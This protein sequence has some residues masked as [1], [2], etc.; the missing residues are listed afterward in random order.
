MK[1]LVLFLQLCIFTM[2]A[3]AQPGQLS[4][5]RIDHM[6]DLPVSLQIR[7]WDAVAR[8]YDSFV[9]DLDKTGTYL[10]LSRLGIQ[11][12]FNYA[13]NT[14]LFMDSYVGS[15]DHLNLAEAIN[16]LP[17]I[18]GASLVGIDKSNQQGMNWVAMAKDFYNLENGQNV[19]LNGYSTQSGNDWWYDLMPNVYFYQLNSLYPEGTPEF[20]TQF[21]AVA[22]QWLYCVRQLG[23][24]TSPWTIPNMNYRA[25]DL[26]TGQPLSEGVPEPESAG[27]IA[28]L[29]YNAY[30]ETGNREYM[31]GARQ[32]MD[33]LSGFT[34]N[35]SYELQLPYGT[36]A[37]ARMNAVE[38]DN[39][40]VQQLLDWCFERGPLRGWGAI[41]GNWNGQE[42]S[43]LIGEANDNGNDYAFVMNGFQQAAALAPLPKY[44]KRYARAL[45]KWLLN[46][47]HA[48]RLFYHNALPEGNQDSYAWAAA[49]DPSA[50]I[51]Y[52]AMKEVWQGVGPFA[53][54]DAIRGGW[55]STNLSLY[56]GSSVGYLAAVSQTTNVPGILQIDLNSTDFYGDNDLTSWMYFNPTTGSQ[57]VDVNLPL[58]DYGIYEAITETD[59]MASAS[60]T[61][62]L[63]IPSGEV[64]LIR[65]YSPGEAPESREGK[66][67][68]GD[69]VLDYHYQY[70]YESSL[71]VKALS[72]P[73]PVVAGAS[74]TAWAE[75]GNVSPQDIVQY[76]WYLNDVLVQGQ[77]T[78]QGSLTASETPSEI[79]LRSRI[80]FNDQ[81]A[82]DTLHLKVV[83]QILAP[84]MVTGIGS[85]ADYTATGGSNTFT[86]QVTPVAG[87][88]YTYQWSVT[89][90]TLGQPTG[91]SISWQAPA[92]PSVDTVRV[93]VTNQE[94]L[95]TTV[96][97]TIVVK[98]VTLAE[99]EPLIWYPFDND[100]QNAAADRFH[101]T[102]TGAEK[103]SDARGNAEGAY[104]FTS[105]ENIIS[106]PND[107]ELNFT[108]AV[109]LSC[110]VKAE[111]LG[112]ERYVISHGSW[113]QRYKLSIIPEGKFR[114]TVRTDAG[115]VDLDSETIL[116][117]DRYYH[118]TALFTG[119]SLELYIDGV[120]DAATGF[121]G[122]LLSSTHPLTLGR[123]DEVEINYA[124]LG[125]IDEVKV[126]DREIPVSQIEKLKD[127]WW[128]P[129]GIDP[130]SSVEAA[131]RIYPNPSEGM[132]T[133]EFSGT[134]HPEQLSLFAA[135]G[136]KVVEYQVKADESSIQLELPQ[137]SEGIYL[138][139][140]RMKDGKVFTRKVVG[141]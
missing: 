118:V 111:E 128:F 26:S 34:S 131:V 12:Q 35:P 2:L 112:M 33:F 138:L 104:R 65:L 27:S 19:Y 16:I 41:V 74:F 79:I 121:S 3:L 61:Y 8:D 22:D 123:Q 20:D 102:V 48:S 24:S 106:T 54:G 66:L 77:T 99:Q 21:T 84:P 43:G 91:A 140:I 62:Q 63:T 88:T 32:A 85:A 1:R 116:E 124:L 67:Y 82:E 132:V 122:S 93:T 83:S 13:D 135:D 129:V 68:S 107:P 64:R 72:A 139:R 130:G 96:S 57:Q 46:L 44:D 4:I 58:G 100:D 37:A 136:R 89:S 23:G 25:F 101:A 51:P 97:K 113:Q 126:W 80:T 30:L 9:F 109:S 137:P 105:G 36:I 14:P 28:W 18:V 120:L 125:S 95:S 127:Q 47:S 7:D 87:E 49:N 108:E 5:A 15:D 76:E 50:S 92:A 59:L 29:L 70:N 56:S 134:S 40:P 114:W 31:E 110:W 141:K 69:E 103:T 53:T 73:N 17:A 94:Q 81:T 90:G 55:S 71:Q 60:G 38:G 78:A 86:A 6:P 10:P 133:I 119:Y 39:Y 45:A 11:G 52:E 98:D 115:V 42:V 117:L 75:P